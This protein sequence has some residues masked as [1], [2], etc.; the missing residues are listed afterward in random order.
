MIPYQQV[1]QQ[2]NAQQTAGADSRSAGASRSES[3]SD[4]DAN[5]LPATSQQPAF[6]SNT[7]SIGRAS[8][9]MAAG[10]LVSRVLGL[11]RTVLLTALIGT[12]VAGNVWNNANQLPNVIYILLAGGVINAVLVP[13]I[14]RALTYDDGGQ[15]YTDRLLTLAMSLLLGVTVI[16]TAAGPLFFKIGFAGA[17]GSTWHLGIIFSFICLPQIFFYGLY[18]LLGE[19][20]NA[21]NR[22]GALM[23][24][25]VLANI[26]AIAGIVWLLIQKPHHPIGDPRD[27]TLPMSLMLGGSVTLGIVTQAVVLIIPLRRAG[28]V[29]RPNFTF[30]GVGLRSMSRVAGWTFAAVIMQ[31][32]GLFVVVGNILNTVAGAGIAQSNAFLLFMLPHSLVTLSL[33]TALFTR[34]S[35]SAHAGSTGAVI[36][37]VRLGLRLSGVTTVPVT[38]GCLVLTEPL[39]GTLFSKSGDTAMLISRPTIGMQ[40]GIIPFTVCA[41]VQRVFFAYESART[42]FF[43]QL[44]C[45]IMTSILTVLCVLLP[46]HW[47]GFGVAL[48]GS[49]TYMVEAAI[50]FRWLQQRRLGKIPM[51]DVIHTYVQLGFAAAIATIATLIVRESIVAVIGSATRMTNLVT[52]V[53]VGAVFVALYVVVARRLRVREIEDLI[54]LVLNRLRELRRLA[55]R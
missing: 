55:G 15:A 5:S 23:W 24:S 6:T 3:K 11:A 39:V 28:Y 22:F 16:C 33:I 8:A 45:T 2:K 17:A 27:W 53:I 46:A 31:Q 19:V 21:H 40:L 35:R 26:F 9:I 50:G 13:Q 20:L 32:V 10:T 34:M 30:R 36:E 49:I 25:P 14:T 42:P 29:W 52:L 7:Y 4:S 18:T 44:V 47:V 1:D 12:S 51:H 37:D 48:I 54:D 43:M 38:L 41:V